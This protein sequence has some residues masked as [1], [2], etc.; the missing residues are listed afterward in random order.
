MQ[1]ASMKIVSKEC[2][3][4]GKNV[5]N[6]NMHVMLSCFNVLSY[7]EHLLENILD[8]LDLEEYI[9]FEDQSIEYQY[10]SLLGCTNDTSF[11]K[12][13]YDK[14]KKVMQIVSNFVFKFNTLFLIVAKCNF[15]HL[16]C[17]YALVHM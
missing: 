15:T 12:L 17:L 5:L 14:S 2:P 3:L 4:C 16:Y 7:R 8:L 6:Y 10:I 13:S 11:R 1:L 9:D